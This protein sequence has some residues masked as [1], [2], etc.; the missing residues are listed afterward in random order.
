MKAPAT[1]LTVWLMKA[2]VATA[3]ELASVAKKTPQF[4]MLLENI[5]DFPF[6]PLPLLLPNMAE[7][8]DAT[9]VELEPEV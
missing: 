5:C 7:E 4:M 9:D 8:V 3:V 6:L 2:E 1:V